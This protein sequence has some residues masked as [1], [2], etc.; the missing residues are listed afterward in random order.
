MIRP[1]LVL[2]L[3]LALLATP[4]MADQ[5]WSCDGG[6][7]SMRLTFEAAT[8]TINADG[9]AYPTLYMSSPRADGAQYATDHSGKSCQTGGPCADLTFAGKDTIMLELQG[10]T[11]T[12]RFRGTADDEESSEE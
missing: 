3:T 12:C 5:L 6:R 11:H 8:L 7:T 1:L 4:A 2:A 10:T 9:V